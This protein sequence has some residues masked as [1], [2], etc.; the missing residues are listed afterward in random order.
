MFC[1]SCATPNP[2]LAVRC[3]SCGIPLDGAATSLLPRSKPVPPPR[4]RFRPAIA[5]LPALA[6][7]VVIVA[8][9]QSEDR[10]A[11]AARAAVSAAF[12]T[13]DYR[14][15]LVAYETLGDPAS[16]R[17]VAALSSV[18]DEVA[19]L[20]RDAARSETQAPERAG[21]ALR[22]AVR[23]LPR[24]RSALPHQTDL[25]QRLLADEQ[26]AYRQASS[27]GDWLGAERSLAALAI[28][29]PADPAWATALRTLRAEHSPLA[30]ARDRALWLVDP[31]EEN[32]SLLTD[33]VS[34]TR[35]VWS[36]DRSRIAFV[37][38]DP[39]DG[40]APAVLYT[41]A[42]D[43]S[44][45]RLVARSIH[46]NALPSWS[47][48]GTAIAATSV[49]RWDLRREAGLLV[50][51]V[52]DVATGSSRSISTSTGLQATSPAW[53]PDGGGV[54]FLAR[55]RLDDP[56]QNPLSGAADVLLWAPA[57]GRIRNL[58]NGS[59]PDAARLVWSPDGRTLLV[60]TRARGLPG[61]TTSA[62]ASIVAL[63]T[64]SLDRALVAAGIDAGAAVWSPAFSPDGSVLAWTD[65]PRRVTIRARAGETR[66]LDTQRFLSGALT[67][68]PGGDALLAVAADPSEPS[69]RINPAAAVPVTDF[70]V[71]FDGEWPTGTPQWSSL[72]QPPPESAATLSGVGLDP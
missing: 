46:P 2:R 42:A 27:A 62:S 24:D 12:A 33:D 36:P 61:E 21:G 5:A 68:S 71:G 52:V 14:A 39:Y 19:G 41:I 47:P 31:G 6:L 43:G 37:S 29:E 63:D 10:G 50:V 22:A 45:L 7:L 3:R 32:G 15:A 16:A 38:S 28:L 1:T 44:D 26:G 72:T 51:N 20:E 8:L 23:L 65:G 56:R 54:A 18:L 69:A 4:V 35:P 11:S 48:D 49:A 30:L 57:D 34:V 53:S 67:W 60:T 70:A 59:L 66:S 9:R 64:V 13:G 17:A 55:S 58:T 25:R 40:R